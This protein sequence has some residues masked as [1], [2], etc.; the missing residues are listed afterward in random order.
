MTSAGYLLDTNALSEPVRRMPAPA[1]TAFMAAI[2]DDETF[3]SVLTVGELRRGATMRRQTD[4][5]HAARI[6]TWI[7]VVERRFAGRILSVDLEIADL[8]GKLSAERPRPVVDA[9]LAATAIVHDL[10]LV[11]RNVADFADTGVAL[12]NPWTV[13]LR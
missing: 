7:D 1:V 8:W 12:V 13:K 9:L 4:S 11:T 2:R 3:L 6:D 5:R 10:T